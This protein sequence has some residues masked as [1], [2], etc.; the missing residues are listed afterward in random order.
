ML[1]I[2]RPLCPRALGNTV[3]L[4]AVGNDKN[5]GYL[6]GYCDR[7][8]LTCRSM[9]SLGKTEPIARGQILYVF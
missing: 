8:V 6:P 1:I 4:Q 9:F 7:A 5:Y 3:R 2:G